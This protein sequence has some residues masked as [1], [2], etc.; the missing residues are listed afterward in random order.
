M[1]NFWNDVQYVEVL[2]NYPYLN[3]IILYWVEYFYNSYIILKV[4]NIILSCYRVKMS[5]K[6]G[7]S[8]PLAM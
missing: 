4:Y 7:Q 5:K 3:Y 1:D 8:Q 6:Y 2:F